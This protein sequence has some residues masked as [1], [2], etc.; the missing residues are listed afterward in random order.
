MQFICYPVIEGKEEAE[1]K[2]KEELSEEKNKIVSYFGTRDLWPAV[3][4]CFQ[5]NAADVLATSD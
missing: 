4:F 2:N 5:K 1:E 3:D